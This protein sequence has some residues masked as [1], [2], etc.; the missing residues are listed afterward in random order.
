MALIVSA[1]CFANTISPITY[2]GSFTNGD[3]VGYSI[4]TDGTIGVLSQ[5]NIE[6]SSMTISNGAT[7][8]LSATGLS[9]F[10]LGSDLTAT[11]TALSFEFQD[12][13]N[14]DIVE[15]Y[16]NSEGLVRFD[17]GIYGDFENGSTYPA[18][19]YPVTVYSPSSD[20]IATTAVSSGTPEPGTILLSGTGLLL[21]A[22]WLRSSKRTRASSPSLR[23]SL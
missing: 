15:F 3:T 9:A 1:S 8:L 7:T 12:N 17:D 19:Q 16:N 2:T 23:Q 21:A 18:G 10:I 6:T 13:T 4:T 20:V 11:S 5:S 14:A 22:A